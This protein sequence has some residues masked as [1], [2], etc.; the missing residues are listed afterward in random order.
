MENTISEIYRE[1]EEAHNRTI[2]PNRMRGPL[3]PSTPR[4]ESEDDNRGTRRRI[5]Q[6]RTYSHQGRAYPLRVAVA[7]PGI[8]SS[9]FFRPKAARN[10]A[11]CGSV[12]P[13]RHIRCSAT[14][15]SPTSAASPTFCLL[16]SVAI[17]LTTDAGGSTS[18]RLPPSQTP[19]AINPK[20]ASAQTNNLTTDDNLYTF[21]EVHRPFLCNHLYFSGGQ[22]RNLRYVI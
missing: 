16:M 11:V 6:I 13:V 22:R 2:S 9:N 12:P 21:L 8:N 14:C 18:H 3:T 20:S 1:R 10:L 19:I 5:A 15:I 17:V 7:T 4:N